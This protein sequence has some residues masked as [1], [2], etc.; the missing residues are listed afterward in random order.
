M[1]CKAVPVTVDTYIMYS[2]SEQ[3]NIVDSQHNRVRVIIFIVTR[4]VAF[5]HDPVRLRDNVSELG[6]VGCCSNN[7]RKVVEVFA[8]VFCFKSPAK[9]AVAVT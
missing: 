5:L 1:V 7:T 3:V 6:W 4:S 2:A 8:S 9:H